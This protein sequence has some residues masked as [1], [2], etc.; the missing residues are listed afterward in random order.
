MNTKPFLYIHIPKTAGV[1]ISVSGLVKPKDWSNHNRASDIDKLGDFYSFCF[2]R[3]PYH[4]IYSS[5]RFYTTQTER[6]NK[7]NRRKISAFK[8]YSD[9]VMGFPGSAKCDNKHFATQTSYVYGGG[10]QLVDYVGKFET[11]TKDWKTIQKNNPIYH[12]YTELPDIN[13][14][15]APVLDIYTPEMAEKI[16][17]HY[18][19]DFINFGYDKDSYISL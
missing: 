15:A 18:K 14:S 1:S 2:V 6:G 10:K 9:F 12:E 4:R 3:N 16:Y 5:Y 13:K 11:L 17:N 7:N 19:D 8:T